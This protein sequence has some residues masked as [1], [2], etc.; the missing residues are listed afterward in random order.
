[1]LSKGFYNLVNRKSTLWIYIASS[2]K[3]LY[4]VAVQRWTKACRLNFQTRKPRYTEGSLGILQ[5]PRLVWGAI[6]GTL[7]VFASHRITFM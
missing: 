3:V 4:K 7:W 1:M 2:T 5:Q 6:M